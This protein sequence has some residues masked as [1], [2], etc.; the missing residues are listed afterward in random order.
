[1]K[2]ILFGLSAII[3]LTSAAIAGTETYSKETTQAVPDCPEWYADSEFN[4]TLSGVYAPT[5]NSWRED[6]YLGVDHA[7]GGSLDLKYFTHRYFGF[8]LQGTLLS[9]NDSEVF[10][11]GFTRVRVDSDDRHA[12]GSLLGTF[13]VRFPIRCSRVAP[14]FWAGGGGIFGGGR[15]HDFFLDP[16]TPTGVVRRE[17]HSSDTKMLAQGGG[18]LEI[19][20]TR[21]CGWI[22]DFSWNVVSGSKNNFG[23]ARTG[24][25]LAF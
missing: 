14:Y 11:D 15:D 8:G 3:A 20:F 23:M 10:D 6:T 4:V 21:R 25:N 18:G 17:F 13:T 5:G 7:W 22:N 12:V 1:M 24:I 19:R 9:V 16:T 2:K